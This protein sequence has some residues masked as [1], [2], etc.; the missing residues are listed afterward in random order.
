MYEVDFKDLASGVKVRLL[1]WFTSQSK[2]KKDKN[3]H[4]LKNAHG[5]SQELSL[6]YHTCILI[7]RIYPHHQ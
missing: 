3:F 4:E 2:D 1:K 5:S 7:E 6:H